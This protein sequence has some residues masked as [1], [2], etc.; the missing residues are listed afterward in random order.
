MDQKLANVL[1]KASTAW[2]NVMALYGGAMCSAQILE[3]ELVQILAF[4]HTKTGVIKEEGSDWAYQKMLYEKPSDVLIRIKGSG[5]NL[6]LESQE[7]VRK[8]LLTRN[9]L[10]HKF[11]HQ[12]GPIMSAAESR[13]VSLKLIRI[14]SELKTAF[15]L[16]QPLRLQLEKEL[17]LSPRRQNIWEDTRARFVQ[18]IVSFHDE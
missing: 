9:F 16:L 18:A 3:R 5:G 6:S 7:I 1:E 8:A 4:L 17:G 10:A 15:D 11:F 12:Y 14:D 13:R 2:R